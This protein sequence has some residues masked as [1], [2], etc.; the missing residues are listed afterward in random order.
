MLFAIASYVVAAVALGGAV[1]PIVAEFTV[2][3]LAV[4][5]VGA[6]TLV[7]A[8]IL[9]VTADV[10]NAFVA[11]KVKEYTAFGVSAVDVVIDVDG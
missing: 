9:D 8:A 7:V 2:I 6:A 1:N 10:P 4:P 3:E 11:V 5:I